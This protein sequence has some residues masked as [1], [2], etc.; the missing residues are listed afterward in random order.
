MTRPSVSAAAVIRQDVGPAPPARPGLRDIAEIMRQPARPAARGTTTTTRTTTAPKTRLESA[1]R[2]YAQP[3]SLL[4]A[5]QI[6]AICTAVL[7]VFAI[8]T[9]AFAIMAFGK[10]SQQ[11][12]DQQEMN[13]QQA[14]M[15]KLQA[16]DLQDSLGERQRDREQRRRAQAAQVLVW[17]GQDSRYAEPSLVPYLSNSSRQPIYDLAVAWGS[18]AA[19]SLPHLLPGEEHEFHG[20]GSAV[21]NDIVPVQLEFR[22]AN[23]VRWLTTSRGELTERSAGME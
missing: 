17:L 19:G 5:A 21:A 13:R 16:E 7:A 10:Q 1:S 14:G 2:A 23:G 20:A 15:F 18:S 6:T 11:L 9:A 4:V 12:K 3:M 8:V 22:D